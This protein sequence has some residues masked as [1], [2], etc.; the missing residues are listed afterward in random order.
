MSFSGKLKGEIFSVKCAKMWHVASSKCRQISGLKQKIHNR[1]SMANA[2]HTLNSVCWLNWWV[3]SVDSASSKKKMSYKMESIQ[4]RR[5]QTLLDVFARTNAVRMG[6]R[7]GGQ[8]TSDAAVSEGQRLPGASCTE[9]QRRVGMTAT[10][11]ATATAATATT[12]P[13]LQ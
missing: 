9:H 5:W 11:A 8:I 6:W 4:S 7:V 3:T 2:W 13:S 10:A 1:T 12:T